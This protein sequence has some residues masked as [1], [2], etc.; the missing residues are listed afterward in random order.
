MFVDPIKEGL[1]RAGYRID[2]SQLG[3]DAV[4]EADVCIIGTGAGGGIATDIVQ[5][6]VSGRDDREGMLKDLR[7]LPHARVGGIPTLYQESA[8]RK[9]AD[10]DD[11]HPAGTHGWRLNDGELDPAS[12]SGDA[13]ALARASDYRPDRRRT[14]QAG[15]SSRSN[16]SAL[17]TG[18]CPPMRTIAF[19]NAVVR[20]VGVKVERIRHQR[21]GLL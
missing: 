12:G 1:A 8:S 7:R 15:S 3:K 16:C 5:V 13:Q 6:P 19:S 10:K 18:R 9:T 20:K 4:L 17:P 14:W 11:Q 2:A 21:E